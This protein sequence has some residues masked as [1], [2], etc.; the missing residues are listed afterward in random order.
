MA[1]QPVEEAEH[2]GE[3]AIAAGEV[4]IEALLLGGKTLQ[5]GHVDVV[6]HVVAQAVDHHDQQIL[7]LFGRLDIEGV[8]RVAQPLLAA[9][10]LLGLGL[11]LV[12]AEIQPAMLG[13][14]V[15]GR[16]GVGEREVGF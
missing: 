11:L 6:E 1:R 15:L 13:Q 5:V 14:E 4:R 3:I 9:L 8:Q 12:F 2:A 7:G 16:H 10:V